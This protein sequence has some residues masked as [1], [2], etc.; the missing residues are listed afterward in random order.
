MPL[1]KGI[2]RLPSKLAPLTP[3]SSAGEPFTSTTPAP[4]TTMPA[5]SPDWFQEVRYLRRTLNSER[6]SH[7]VIHNLL[8]KQVTFLEKQVADL[9]AGAIANTAANLTVGQR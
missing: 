9:R 7:S 5:P 2:R 6:R 3:Q 1:P 8:T 4:A